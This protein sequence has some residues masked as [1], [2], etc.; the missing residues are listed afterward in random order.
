VSVAFS[1]A[2]SAAVRSAE[3][4]VKNLTIIAGFHNQDGGYFEK[5]PH[6]VEE[7]GEVTFNAR[8]LQR[9]HL[10]W[11]SGISEIKPC[12]F[13]S[14]Q[15]YTSFKLLVE[16]YACNSRTNWCWMCFAGILGRVEFKGAMVHQLSCR[17]MFCGA[18]TCSPRQFISPYPTS[19][20]EMSLAD[21]IMP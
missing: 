13:Q 20:P 1:C 17:Q 8:S 10:N 21:I 9:N 2:A 5:T 18:K 7:F 3:A 15:S 12:Y 11:E 4:S 6:L 14:L 19:H 16:R